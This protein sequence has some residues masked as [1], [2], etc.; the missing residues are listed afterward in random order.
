[1][2]VMIRRFTTTLVIALLVLAFSARSRAATTDTAGAIGQQHCNLQVEPIKPGRATS[3]VIGMQ[4][5]TSY[6]EALRH[7]TGGRI[8]LAVGAGP[9]DVTDAMRKQASV[10]R[11]ATEGDATAAADYVISQSWTGSAFRGSSYTLTTSQAKMCNGYTYGAGM[12]SSWNDVISSGRAWG[13]CQYSTHRDH[14]YG[15]SG[16]SQI[17]CTGD[18]SSC[19]FMGAMNDATSSIAV[20][21]YAP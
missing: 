17:S 4:C 13:N 18:W 19:D 3:Q 2:Q 21:G 5:F 14:A 7:A 11:Q 15:V 6:A 8:H 16:G 1:M 10:T 20:H 9:S 12:P